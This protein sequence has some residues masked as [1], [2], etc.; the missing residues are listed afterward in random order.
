MNRRLHTRLWI[1]ATV[2][3]LW[4][5]VVLSSHATHSMAAAAL[6]EISI[7]ATIDHGCHHPNPSVESTVCYAHCSQGGQSS[8]VGRVPPVLALAPVPVFSFSAIV[9]LHADR[10]IG[11]NL[12]PPVSWHRPTSHPA[13]VLLI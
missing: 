2:A 5:Q 13:S 6:A 7:P 1:L 8:E 4:S 12:P 9:S 3:L 11:G 10:A